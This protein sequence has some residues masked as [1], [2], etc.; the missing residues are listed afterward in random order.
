MNI[1]RLGQKTNT[2]WK[3]W[4]MI[5]SRQIFKRSQNLE[6]K[7][8]DDFSGFIRLCMQ[9]VAITWYR[10]AKVRLSFQFEYNHECPLKQNN[11]YYSEK[12]LQITESKQC[13][14]HNVQDIV[15]NDSAIITKTNKQKYEMLSIKGNIQIQK[16]Q[17]NPDIGFVKS[18]F[19][20]AIINYVQWGKGRY[21]HNKWKDKY[22]QHKNSKWKKITKLLELK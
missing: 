17:D 1:Y 18:N 19:K 15:Q 4:E 2:I 14:I 12:I 13:H 11:W 10:T 3:P 8:T 20:L 22:S 9:I 5:R 6:K 7:I 16:L 21:S